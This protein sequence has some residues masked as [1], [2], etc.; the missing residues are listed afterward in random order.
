VSADVFLAHAQAA[1]AG[2]EPVFECCVGGPAG[3]VPCEVR[4]VRFRDGDAGRH[5][6]ASLTDISARKRVESDLEQR[7]QVLAHAEK[8][9]DMGALLAGVA[10]E[11]NNPLSVVVGQAQLIARE[12]GTSEIARRARSL[13]Q[14]ADRCA[15]IVH[16]FLS[17]ARQQPPERRPVLLN[18]VLQEALDLISYPLRVDDVE[19]RLDLAADLPPIWAD[20]HQ[21]HQVVVNLLTNA[22]H[23]LREQGGPR[24]VTVTT[25]ARPARGVRLLIADNGPGIPEAIRERVFEP[26]FTTKPQGQGTGLGLSLCRGIVEAHG[27][28]LGLDA[29][30]P[31]AGAAFVID[32]PLGA[33]A[34]LEAP[35]AAETSWPVRRRSILVVDDEA[36]VAEL[37][38][39][40][41]ADEGHD[42]ETA[43]TGAAGFERTRQRGFDLVITDMK[44]PG[45]GGPDLYRAVQESSS[46]VPRPAF[47]FMTGDALTPE[48]SAFLAQPGRLHLEKP[49]RAEAVRQILD[50]LFAA[51][52]Q[53]RSS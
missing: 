18:Q 15:R 11:L 20:A 37:L 33:P 1:A 44:M 34:G 53:C 4:L 43:A 22:Q 10:H 35:G 9:A 38:A 2:T 24:R 3:P 29:R 26:F 36:A 21:L 23:A 48:T 14:A 49:F 12:A 27:G 25:A 47:V 30:P 17:L 45:L 41:L 5:V 16:N 40:L 46:S 19:I 52:D 42:V 8:M 39:E 6:R 28:T 7:R 32:L 13:D 31:G 51:A 50:A